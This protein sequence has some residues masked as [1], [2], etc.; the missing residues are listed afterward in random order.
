MKQSQPGGAHPMGEV[1]T[2][3]T[4]TYGQDAHAPPSSSRPVEWSLIYIGAYNK[5]TYHMCA[6][7]HTMGGTPAL[8]KL[9]T[10]SYI[11][12]C[13]LVLFR[14]LMVWSPSY[15]SFGMPDCID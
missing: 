7:T 1:H 13:V 4:L 15:L 10:G 5:G 2:M 12:V 8:A 6:G 3:G 9:G 14:L 11:Y